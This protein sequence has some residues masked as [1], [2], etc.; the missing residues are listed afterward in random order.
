MLPKDAPMQVSDFSKDAPGRFVNNIDG[1]PTFVPHPL[2]GSL[3]WS[4]ELGAVISTAERALGR[5]M[6]IGITLPNSRIVGE[7]DKGESGPSGGLSM[8]CALSMAGCP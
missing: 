6:G 7:L 1:Y 8:S 4:N 5:L 2:P 3:N